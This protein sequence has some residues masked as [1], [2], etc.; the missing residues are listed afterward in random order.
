MGH[1]P[2]SVM[3]KREPGIQHPKCRGR[4][5]E[6]VDR[7]RKV[8]R[9]GEEPSDSVPADIHAELEQ[10]AMNAPEHAWSPPPT[11]TVRELVDAVRPRRPRAEYMWCW[12]IRLLSIALTDQARTEPESKVSYA[13]TLRSWSGCVRHLTF[14]SSDRQFRSWLKHLHDVRDKMKSS[15]GSIAS[16]AFG[17]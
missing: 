11:A 15:R 4:D 10:F 7:C 2:S 16:F 5:N 13:T 12:Q 9:V 17:A 3:V 14:V 8:R 6:H 1:R